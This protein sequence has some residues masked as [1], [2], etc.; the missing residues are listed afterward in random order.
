MEAVIVVDL[1]WVMY[2]TAFSLKQMEILTKS[3]DGSFMRRPTGHVFGTIRDVLAL[4]RLADRVVLCVDSKNTRRKEILSS[5]KED[6]PKDGYSVY[7]DLINILKITTLLPNV[8]Y[9]K[10]PEMESDD[11]IASYVNY[12][13]DYQIVPTI[14]GIDNDLMQT[15]KPF[16]M[17]GAVLQGQLQYIDTQQYIFEKYDLELPY[18]PIWQQVLKGKGSNKVPNLVPRL[19]KRVSKKIIMENAS[20]MDLGRFK[21]D[22]ENYPAVLAKYPALT[23]EA[24]D[25]NYEVNCPVY[26]DIRDYNY[27]QIGT[28][29]E[30]ESL[31]A[32]YQM[33]SLMSILSV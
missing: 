33:N 6:R 24:L 23:T 5:Y 1:S 9:V 29:D 10:E 13:T 31:L 21:E 17:A 8:F 3:P 22:L 30:V 4:S 19:D 26:K 20:H 25:I 11:L 16:K 27:K 18:I 32:M 14:F 28:K 7:N 12:L 2:R 15:P